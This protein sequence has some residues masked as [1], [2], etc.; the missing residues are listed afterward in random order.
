[1]IKWIKTYYGTLIVV[2]VLLLL[3]QYST[4][5]FKGINPILFPKP[6]AVFTALWEG[7]K[8]LIEGFFSSMYLLLSG[9]LSAVILGIIGGIYFGLHRRM[10]HVLMPIF[11][12]LSPIPPI[13]YTPY[14]IALLPTFTSAS[15]TLIFIGAFWPVF[16]STIQGVLLVEQ[17]YL[18]NAK[19]LKLKG[20]RFISKVIIPASLPFIFSGASVA[21][22]FAFVILT[23]AEMFGAK[24][25]MGYYIQYYSDFSD[26]R[27][28]IAGMIFNSV[29][30]LAIVLLFEFIRRKLLFWT[31]LK[32]DKA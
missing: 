5:F 16:L 4:D 24:S 27:N 29:I 7:R 3:W 13:L 6:L 11:H 1:M 22:G 23:V 14:A 18:D 31:Q 32:A 17:P 21:L 28:V 10:R 19:V 30:I 12:S 2:L 25:G 15:I 26:Y 20:Y 8:L 9:Y